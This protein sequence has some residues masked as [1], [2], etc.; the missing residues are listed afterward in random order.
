VSRA[1]HAIGPGT[2]I[3]WLTTIGPL[4]RRVEDLALALELLAGPDGRDPFLAPVPLADPS[5]VSLRGLRVAWFL[6]NGFAPPD[7]PVAAAV[8]AAVRA[9]ADAGARVTAWMPPGVERTEPLFMHV[10][11][12]DGG[13][14]IRR[15]LDAAGTDPEE[16]SLAGFSAAP[17]MGI[18]ERVRVVAEWD[19]LRADLLGWSRDWDLVVSPPNAHAA[20]PHGTTDARMRAFSYT[21]TWN[22]AGWPG[23]VVRAGATPEGLP[24]GVQLVAPPWRE[25]VALA[26][27]AA[28]EAALG[29]WQPPQAGDRGVFRCG[30][31]GGCWASSSLRRLEPF[32][33]S[34]LLCADDPPVPAGSEGAGGAL[35]RRRARA[36]PRRAGARRADPAPAALDRLGR[37]RAA[38][39]G[40]PGESLHRVRE[41]PDRRPRRGPRRD[42]RCGCRSSS[43]SSAGRGSTRASDA[44]PATAASIARGSASQTDRSPRRRS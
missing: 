18:D 1:G 26:A 2:A 20:L 36:R 39:R 29:G 37:D 11:L 27:A 22:L 16:S 42:E 23:A 28:I 31:A 15:L 38:R 43:S 21:M 32:S 25:E 14:G 4:A 40:L 35:R 24:L 17:A 7:A 13:A 33:R 9:L 19:R 3:D 41:R 6:D 34:G 44:Q 10:F 12:L 8:E 30:S 5:A